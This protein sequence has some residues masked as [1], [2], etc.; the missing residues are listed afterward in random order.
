MASDIYLKIEGIE[1]ES[2]DSKHKD[3]IEVMS[4][5][6]G[7]SNPVSASVSGSGG[8]SAGRVSIGD[9]NVMKMADKASPKI[10]GLCAQGKEAKTA[11]IEVCRSTKNGQ[12]PYMHYELSDVFI[13][14]VQQAGSGEGGI[15]S[16]SLSLAFAKVTARY[17]PVDKTG[18]KQGNVPFGWDL[19]KNEKV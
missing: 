17:V 10:F 19:S 14:S 5:S 11:T 18:A 7:A 6:W 12:E 8:F 1:G 9:F 2:T 16:E 3:W 4:F 15:P 13:T